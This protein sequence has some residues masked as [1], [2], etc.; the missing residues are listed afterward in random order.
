MHV[1]EGLEME[2]RDLY[3]MARADELNPPGALALARGLGL[4]V[5]WCEGESRQA[6]FEWETRTIW[7]PRGLSSIAMNYQIGHEIAEF[8]C[9]RI[10]IH[11]PE[12]ER[13]CDALGVRLL[14]PRPAFKRALQVFGLN[15]VELRGAFL[16]SETCV[17]LRIGEVRGQPIAVVLPDRILARGGP[18]AWG[19]EQ[20]LR[21]LALCEDLP[22]GVHRFRLADE[23]RR[24]V[25]CEDWTDYFD[26]GSLGGGKSSSVTS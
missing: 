24:V 13:L 26:Q 9:E 6:R 17:S 18:W 12:R 21:E 5:A 8:W 19:S 22:K 10:G 3:E 15:L 7:V 4:R 1:F 16:L 23:P 11:S 2:G 25:L 14:A 20:T